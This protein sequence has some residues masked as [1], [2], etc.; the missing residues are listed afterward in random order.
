[1]NDLT[2]THAAQGTTSWLTFFR[3]WRSC[4]LTL[5]SRTFQMQ[6]N[7]LL[8]TREN[9]P[10][11]A[12]HEDL[13]I[14][15][16]EKSFCDEL[17]RSQ[18]M[19]CRI[20]VDFLDAPDPEREY[21]YFH[22]ETFPE[23]HTYFRLLLQ[24]INRPSIYQKKMCRLLSVALLTSLDRSRQ[25]TLSLPESTMVSQTRFGRVLKYMGDH[26]AACTLKEIAAV[27]GYNPDYLSVRFKEITGETFSVKLRS[28][29]LEQA[30]RMLET[31]PMT[32]EA[33]AAAVG[34]RDK[35]WFMRC[36][37]KTYGETPARYRRNHKNAA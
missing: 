5:S 8:L 19:E 12:S 33:V 31:T 20:L 35:S 26:Y 21:L 11:A 1:M 7:D 30:A 18:I 23:I 22:T 29:R 3:P 32:V 34:F 27:F 25:Q 13:D 2:L 10:Y 15:G 16:M 9:Q 36:F 17:M 37:K 6:K 28:I 24:E 14:L 4:S